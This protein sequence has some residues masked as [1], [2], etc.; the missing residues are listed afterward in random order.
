MDKPKEEEM[1]PQIKPENSLPTDLSS[2]APAAAPESILIPKE[3]KP[4][5]KVESPPPPPEKPRFRIN[6]PKGRGVKILAG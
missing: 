6:L 2:P 5:T 3:L 4:Q 1:I